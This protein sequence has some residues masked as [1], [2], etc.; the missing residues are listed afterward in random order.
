MT[1]DK[2][3]ARMTAAEFLALPETTQPTELLDGE[4]LMSPSPVPKHQRINRR[5]CRLLEDII[6]NGEVFIAPLDVY[7]DEAN[8]P[9]P[10]VIWV[11]QESRCQITEKRLEGP[12]DLIIEVV[13]PGSAIVDRRE[14]FALYERHGV[15]EYWIAE[16]QAQFVEVCTLR[17]GRYERLGIFGANE[18]FDSPALGRTVELSG[19]FG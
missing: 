18:R 1:L 13:S 17:G 19:V 8:I 2:L 11:A 3:G 10:D 6:P 5:F 15:A 4:L 7:L 9:Q 14:K 12:P 16:P